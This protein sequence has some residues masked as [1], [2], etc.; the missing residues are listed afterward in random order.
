MFVRDPAGDLIG[1]LTNPPTDEARYYLTDDQNSVIATTDHDAD[2]VIRYLYEPYGQTIRSWADPDAG[3]QQRR[4][5][6]NG[7][8][9]LTGFPTP[10]VDHNPYRYISGYTD[11]DTGLIKFGTRYYIPT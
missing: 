6:R 8:E 3:T 2:E 5:H 11:P 1:M 9:T 10:T 4:H 7:A